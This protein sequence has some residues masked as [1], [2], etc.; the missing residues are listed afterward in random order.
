MSVFS[1]SD[2]DMR[3][4]A[5]LKQYAADTQLKQLQFAVRCK[6][7]EENLTLLRQE[8]EFIKDA[9]QKL[10][11][12]PSHFNSDIKRAMMKWRIKL[13]SF[14][15]EMPDLWFIQIE[16][17]FANFGITAEIDKYHT[18]IS[19]SEGEWLVEI[20]D[21]I[22][23]GPS[24]NIPYTTLKKEIIN[25][26]S[27]DENPRLKKV[28]EGEEIGDLKPSQF[29]RR[30]KT[31]AGSAL[32]TDNILKPLWLSRLPAYVQYILR[33]QPSNNTLTE[34]ADVADRIAETIPHSVHSTS[35]TAPINSPTVQQISKP[36][37]LAN[38]NEMLTS[39][40][41]K[42]DLVDVKVKNLERNIDRRK[43][44]SRPKSRSRYSLPKP[45]KFCFYHEKFGREARK[46]QQPCKFLTNDNGSQ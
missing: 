36:N 35:T 33:A 40:T 31:V 25:R 27:L 10:E 17:I 8:C 11:E 14:R 1:L 39:L 3:G 2:I 29:L 26:F 28:I 30:L 46:C 43:S 37:P 23:A 41:H 13:P 12:Q 19:Q 9:Q 22:R 32:I 44:C 20:N 4:L 38:I 45:R 16:T 21:L 34:I 6:S 15:P 18:V 5:K 7:I 24:L 42:V